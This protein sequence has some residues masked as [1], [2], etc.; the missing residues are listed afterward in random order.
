MRRTLVS[1]AVTPTVGKC[2][3]SSE[4]DPSA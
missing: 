1:L 2:S 3:V 4:A